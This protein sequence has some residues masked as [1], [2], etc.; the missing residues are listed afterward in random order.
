MDKKINNQFDEDLK[1][2]SRKVADALNIFEETVVSNNKLVTMYGKDEFIALIMTPYE[3]NP[4]VGRLRMRTKNM[5]S[6]WDKVPIGFS[7]INESRGLLSDMKR[8]AHV[9][10]KRNSIWYMD[11]QVQDVIGDRINFTELKVNKGYLFKI[12]FSNGY[13]ICLSIVRDDAEYNKPHDCAQLYVISSVD[14]TPLSEPLTADECVLLLLNMAMQED[15]RTSEFIRLAEECGGKSL[16]THSYRT[17]E[18]TL[19]EAKAV[20]KNGY[21]LK[22]R[23]FNNEIQV[24]V[25]GRYDGNTYILDSRIFD[26]INNVYEMLKE[27]SKLS[28]Y[29]PVKD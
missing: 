16:I 4:N 13:D 23:I 3:N 26:D 1:Y 27:F 28:K 19:D 20:F 5:A 9:S 17:E 29:E 2:V 22:L 18:E 7:Q 14:K 24:D 12:Q 10:L 6:T 21:A 25:Y 8:A 11:R 15:A